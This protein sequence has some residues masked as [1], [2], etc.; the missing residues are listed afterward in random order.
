MKVYVYVR[1]YA[2]DGSDQRLV[3][4][5]DPKYIPY[6]P[7]APS[8]EVDGVEMECGATGMSLRFEKKEGGR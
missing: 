7:N 1:Q 5:N 6:H 4:S 8:F 3:V 2:S